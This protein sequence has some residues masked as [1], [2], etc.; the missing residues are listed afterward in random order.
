M[1]GPLLFLLY[2]NDIV[3]V[4]HPSVEIRLFADD[5]VL[6]KEISSND[7]YND[8]NSSLCNIHEWCN[9]WGMCL[10]TS[11]CVCLPVTRKKNPISYTYTLGSSPLQ[12]VHFYKYLG[13]TLTSNLSWNLHIDNVCSSAFRKLC[14]LKHKLKTA[15]TNV[16]LLCYTALVRPRLEYACIIWD[17]Y[18][19]RNINSLERI[20]RKAVRFI[21]NKFSPLDSPSDLMQTNDIPLLEARRLKARLEFLYQLYNK[22]LALD[23]SPYLTPLTS[24]S[25]RHQHPNALTPYFARTDLF[26]FSYFP[27]TISEWNCL[28]DRC[29]QTAK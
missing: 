28:T 10:N 9:E 12:Q 15:P 11:K 6:F 25:T 8:L 17:P 22:K 14:L 16:K 5:C 24:R 1:L 29:D 27:R 2:I 23:P 26:K 7:D 13:V 19:K 21:F 3:D 18:T 4:I 20:Q